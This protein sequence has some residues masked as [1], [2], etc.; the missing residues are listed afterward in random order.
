M[1][2]KAATSNSPRMNAS[3]TGSAIFGSRISL[4]SRLAT[5]KLLKSASLSI[6]RAFYRPRAAGQV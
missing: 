6:A 3:Q 4:G 5:S 2:W 1:A